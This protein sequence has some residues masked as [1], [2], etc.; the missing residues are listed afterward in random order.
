MRN[1]IGQATTQQG[2][3]TVMNLQVKGT[4]FPSPLDLYKGTR[5]ETRASCSVEPHAPTPTFP[6]WH[7]CAHQSGHTLP[8]RRRIH[9]PASK[10][11]ASPS[12]TRFR[13]PAY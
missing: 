3:A 6:L 11:E 13:S 7:A 9:G 8:R 1:E 10:I 4:A 5:E 12:H 2:F